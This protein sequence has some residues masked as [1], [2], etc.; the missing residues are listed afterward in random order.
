MMKI[1][2]AMSQFENGKPAN[3]DDLDAGWKKY[4]I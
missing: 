3:W 1:V 4:N 2:A